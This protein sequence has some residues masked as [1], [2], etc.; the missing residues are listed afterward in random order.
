MLMLLFVINC[1][2]A[3]C[4]YGMFNG[5]I[6]SRQVTGARSRSSSSQSSSGRS[7]RR[8]SENDLEVARL[9][10]AIRQQQAYQESQREYTRATNEYYAAQLAQQQML[11]QVSVLCRT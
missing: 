10:D 1:D 9:Q 4:R 5:V 7:R 8:P 11:L 6:D 2:V 3:S